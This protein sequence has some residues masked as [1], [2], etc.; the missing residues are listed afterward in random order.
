MEL[1]VKRKEGVDR[2]V[3]LHQVLRENIAKGLHMRYEP[4]KE[5]PHSILVLLMQMNDESAKAKT[6]RTA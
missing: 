4:M 3:T 5:M 1:S 6:K 2:P